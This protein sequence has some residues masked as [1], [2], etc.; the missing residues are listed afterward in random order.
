MSRGA[1]RW[2]SRR[3]ARLSAGT[4]RRRSALAVAIIAVLAVSGCVFPIE[5]TS[6]GIRK[7]QEETRTIMGQEVSL[8]FYRN[9]A[10]DCGKSGKFTFLVI[11]PLNNDGAE[12]P[13]WVFLRGGGVGYYNEDGTYQGG[14]A[15]EN[16]FNTEADLEYLVD[17]VNN[18]IFD[19][20]GQPRYFNTL[21]KRL[22][23]GYRVLVPSLCDHDLHSGTGTEYPNNPN[24]VVPEVNGLQANMAATQFVATNKELYPTTDVFVH[25]LSAGS[26]GSY[27]LAYSFAQEGI[28]LTGAIM[29]SYLISDRLQTL[30]DREVVTK[31]NFTA[32]FR[33]EA[34][35]QKIGPFA[36][37]GAGLFPDETVAAGFDDVP[38][39]DLD[40]NDSGYCGGERPPI[41][42][43]E[44]EGRTNCEY[45]HGGLAE[46]ID[47][48]P[49]SPHRSEVYDGVGHVVLTKDGPWIDDVEDWLDDILATNPAPPF[50]GR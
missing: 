39:F 38:L 16:N 2:R 41:P 49:D 4:L 32:G 6:D 44:A 21:L 15:F 48:Q 34:V 11:D 9:E 13:L 3:P 23:E 24:D 33:A 12:A 40:G 35:I 30:I 19:R 5:R 29:D 47:A 14:E 45:L 25:G 1:P 22:L 43:A 37:P 7:V 28:D 46:A 50:A 27:A 26:V 42:E 8:D 36:D 18:N 20:D 10:Y 31:P 17:T